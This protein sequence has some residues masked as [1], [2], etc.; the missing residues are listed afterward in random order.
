MFRP[1]KAVKKTGIKLYNT[2][3]LPTL[4][5]GRETWN[6]KA[7]NAKRITAAEMK[8]MR[9]TAGYSFTGYK[10]NT[11]IAEVLN[12]TPELAKYGNRVEIGCNL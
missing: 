6:I 9:K 2:L 3:D 12:I 4:L 10:T 7:R 11:E 5:Y 1:Q 8:Y